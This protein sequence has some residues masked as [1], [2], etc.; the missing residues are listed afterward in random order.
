MK[1]L[2]SEYFEIPLSGW[3]RSLCTSPE[4]PAFG[5]PEPVVLPDMM[6]EQMSD[7][8][9]F[10]CYETIFE[11]DNPK[12]LFLEISDTSG[13]VEVFMN[14]ETAG[15]QIRPPYHYDLSSLA[16]QGKNYLAIEVAINLGQIDRAVSVSIQEEADDSNQIKKTNI[17]GNIKLY[18]N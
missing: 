5:D 6:T 11:L 8:E 14:G 17:I 10:E 15:M 2:N 4:Y 13:S 12:K 16:R 9:G 3:K 7:F 1:R 18:T